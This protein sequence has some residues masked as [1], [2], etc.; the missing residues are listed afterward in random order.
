MVFSSQLAAHTHMGAVSWG[1][2]EG[3]KPEPSY[4]GKQAEAAKAADDTV[5]LWQ[6]RSFP[7][8]LGRD[9]EEE[10]GKDTERRHDYYTWLLC[11]G[12]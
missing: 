4:L 8:W 2:E 7:T 9:E 1:E 12:T 6:P 3:R 10:E 5:D 11:L